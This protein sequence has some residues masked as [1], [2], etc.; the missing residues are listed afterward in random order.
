MLPLGRECLR[1]S[2][3]GVVVLAIA[4]SC[5]AQTSRVAGAVQGSVVDQ[6]GSP[7]A[8]VT[9][10]L[11]NQGTNQTRTML[12]NAEGF[13]RAGE[14]VVVLARSI[15]ATIIIATIIAATA[16]VATGHQH[17]H[18]LGG[19]RLCNTLALFR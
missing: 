16:T 7:V 18:R 4:F 8:G 13:F 5:A 3:A 14:L 19:C 1:L 12:T 9:V 2:F 17:C 10:T 11:H 15:S 6:T